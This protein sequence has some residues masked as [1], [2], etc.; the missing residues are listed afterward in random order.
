M[1]C[2][3]LEAT[4]YIRFVLTGTVDGRTEVVR[5][6][7]LGGTAIEAQCMGAAIY[8]I[9][10]FLAHTGTHVGVLAT[11]KDGYKDFYRDKLSSFP[12]YQVQ[13]LSR[14]I[15]VHFFTGNMIEF[16]RTLFPG[17]FASVVLQKLGVTVR[18]PGLTKILLIMVLKGE[19]GVGTGLVGLFKI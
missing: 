9:G 12:V 13:F 16:H 8:E 15:N 19:S 18:I 2:K 11:G 14:K 4:V 7:G 5:Y 17:I 3:V 10:S 1:S 6:N